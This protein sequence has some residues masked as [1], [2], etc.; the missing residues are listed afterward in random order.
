MTGGWGNTP[1]VPPASLPTF[2][3]RPGHPA[4]AGPPGA[5]PRR[6][7]AG[8]GPR[9]R[10]RD[11]GGRTEC[12][13]NERLHEEC[14]DAYP[15]LACAS[16]GTRHHPS[17]QRTHRGIAPEEDPEVTDRPGVGRPRRAQFALG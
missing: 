16:L 1:V 9:P 8:N 5:C 7:P 11:A 3:P 14:R 6:G 4:T 2:V 12:K 17:L 15:R 10:T 13:P